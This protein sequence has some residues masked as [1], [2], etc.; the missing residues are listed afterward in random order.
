MKASRL[1][2]SSGYESPKVAAVCNTTA[3]TMGLFLQKTN[4]IR[5]YLED[6]VDGRAFHKKFGS[7]IHQ[8][9]DLGDFAKPQ[10]EAVAVS[11]L[12]HLVTNAMECIPECLEYMALLKTEEVF[13]FCAIPQVM[14]IATL[15]ELYNNPKVFTEWSKYESVKQ[16]S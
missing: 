7:N 5:D 10:N 9:I 6:Y 4:I 12:N 15:A 3:N 8:I 14:A 2:T 11:L 16:Q 1:F 13:R